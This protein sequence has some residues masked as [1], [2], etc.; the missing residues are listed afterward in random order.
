MEDRIRAV[1]GVGDVGVGWP[2]PLSGSRWSSVYG[3]PGSALDAQEPLG[4]Y[5]VVTPGYFETLGVPF[6]EGRTFEESDP[7]HSVIVSH[8]IARAA[9]PGGGWLGRELVANP[10]GGGDT[11]FVVVGVVEDVRSMRLR[12]EPIGALYFDARGWSWADWEFDV[13]VRTERTV[14][15][16][17]P[18]L[19]EILAG[20]DPEVPLAG[21]APM[22]ELVDD[23]LE[24]SRAA[25]GLMGLFSGVAGFL[26][27]LGLYGVVAYSVRLRTRELGIRIALGAARAG[28]VRLILV[29]GLRLTLVGVFLGLVG[30]FLLSGLLRSW[31][32]GVEPTDPATYAAAALGLG[33]LSMLAAWLP[34]R[35][36]ARLE[37]MEVLRTE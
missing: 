8:R 20:M 12:D 3:V 28:A 4:D 17:V 29:Q 19:R 1:P 6:V 22:A 23:Q 33:L 31:L 7:R 13:L 35:R 10:W 11:A 14:S 25:L 37:P 16:I 27:F 5:R 32:Y 36:A 2:L 18:E 9:W 30:A 15:D 21:E 26:A 24:A 34:A